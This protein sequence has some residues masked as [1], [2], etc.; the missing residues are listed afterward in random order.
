LQSY[1]NAAEELLEQ[2]DAVTIVAAALKML[3]KEPDETPVKL[4]EEKPLPLKRE[5]RSYDRR[6]RSDSRDRKKGPFKPRTQS[7]GNK[8]HNN[9]TRTNSF[10]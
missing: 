9:K 3:T 2:Q 7:P 6:G 4:T 10:N 5:S 8:R 1:K